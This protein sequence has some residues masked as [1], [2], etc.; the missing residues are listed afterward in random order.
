[1]QVFKIFIFGT[2]LWTSS[3]NVT[4][5][6]HSKQMYASPYNMHTITIS[7][8]KYSYLSMFVR[9]CVHRAA[10][11]ANSKWTKCTANLVQFSRPN[12]GCFRCVSHTV[13]TLF[14]FTYS[15]LLYIA[16][17]KNTIHCKYVY[18]QSKEYRVIY[19]KHSCLVSGSTVSLLR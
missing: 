12:Q 8:R 2:M 4:I 13:Y 15:M 16:Y 17:L 14:S 5:C 3:K 18:L 6:I 1:M 19:P 7:T 9:E 10:S 11:R